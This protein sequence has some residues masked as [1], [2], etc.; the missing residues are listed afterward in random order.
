MTCRI[1]R[2]LK[3]GFCIAALSSCY[4][5]PVDNSLPRLFKIPTFDPSSLILPLP[6][7]L[8]NLFT[9]SINFNH[10]LIN[11]LF[12]IYRIIFLNIVSLPLTLSRITSST[13]LSDTYL[14]TC[15]D[16]DFQID[17]VAAAQI[18]LTDVRTIPLH[19]SNK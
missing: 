12:S 11:N 3:H 7:N 17:L 14:G 8:N 13:N 18:A 6:H 10:N 2:L 5:S 15:I 4:F 9:T 16:S 19:I 1:R